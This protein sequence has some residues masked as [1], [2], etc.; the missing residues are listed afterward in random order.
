[1]ATAPGG[2]APGS[3]RGPIPLDNRAKAAIVVR[4]LLNEGADLPLEELPDDLQARLTQQ[5][6]QMGLVDR[7]TLNS[8]IGEFAGILD[9][10]GLS[11]PKGIA[12]ALSA[13]DGK[14]SVQTAARLRKEA[15]VRAAG[16]PW[17]RLRSLPVQDLADIIQAESI[18][19]AAV[20]LS[21]LDTA[22]AADLLGKLPGP[23]ARR[24]TYAV[25]QTGSVTPQAVDRIG[26]SLAS[27][28]D[29]RPI[30]AFAD[31]PTARVGAIL[32]QSA[33]RTRD[34]MLSAL[35]EADADFAGAV[36]REIFTF[37]H[38]PHRLNARDVPAIIRTVQG[39]VLVTAMAAATDEASAP[40][41]EFILSNMS[42]R[43]ADNLREEIGEK[44]TVKPRDGEAAM[45][46][47]V[48]AI[49]QLEQSGEVT[50]IT[51]DDEDEED[52]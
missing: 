41:A 26:L 22:K 18:E 38:I 40:V 42:T 31:A 10:V 39:D 34:D 44:G 35:D 13:L 24:I 5:M 4:L 3:A 28:L 8:V 49:R 33:A 32:N 17:T 50:L 15:G 46:A 48:A 43:M 20:L 1:M 23:L 52:G 12:G 7:A 11:F 51:Q 19:V 36:R 37:A 9:E 25:S 29:D 6:G 14:I 30:L 47:I 27:Q 45:N 16:D 21:K 2:P